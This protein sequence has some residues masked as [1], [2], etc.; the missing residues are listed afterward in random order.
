MCFLLEFATAIY[1]CTALYFY[2]QVYCYFEQ[3][4]VGWKVIKVFLNF[5]FLS[6]FGVI[7]VIDRA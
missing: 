3:V 5:E 7:T 2:T 6:E 4:N 1:F